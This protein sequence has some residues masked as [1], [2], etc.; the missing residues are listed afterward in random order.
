[1]I[2]RESYKVS[3]HHNKSHNSTQNNSTTKYSLYI[4]TQ[5]NIVLILITFFCAANI[6]LLN[7]ARIP[8]E[9]CFCACSLTV[10]KIKQ[11]S[12]YL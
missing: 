6:I 9:M 4:L 1:M 7:L 2:S 5:N 11:M 3:L 8:T 12:F 10:I